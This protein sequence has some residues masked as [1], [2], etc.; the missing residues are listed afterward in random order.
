MVERPPSPHPMLATD[1]IGGFRSAHLPI[2]HRCTSHRTRMCCSWRSQAHSQGPT[3][4]SIIIDY[5]KSKCIRSAVSRRTTEAGVSRSRLPIFQVAGGGGRG[6]GT[7]HDG[8]GCGDIG[9]RRDVGDNRRRCITGTEHL[10]YNKSWKLEG[11]EPESPSSSSA[12]L[13]LWRAGVWNR[14]YSATAICLEVNEVYTIAWGFYVDVVGVPQ[15]K[16]QKLCY[17]HGH[18]FTFAWKVGVISGQLFYYSYNNKG[19]VEM[20]EKSSSHN[21]NT[22][23]WNCKRWMDGWMG[24]RGWRK[25]GQ[26]GDENARSDCSRAAVK[27]PQVSTIS[28]PPK[29]DED[30]VK[31]IQPLLESQGSTGIATVS[32]LRVEDPLQEW[33]FLCSRWWW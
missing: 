18:S 29:D 1:I 31:P 33:S 4:D 12:G 25:D 10:L 27:R 30:N 14:L 15:G 28:R 26:N 23:A 20:E 32:E 9:W 13:C 3:R 16:E 6:L 17:R 24:G 11:G 19:G 22:R 8:G 2:T 5:P 7:M 21:G